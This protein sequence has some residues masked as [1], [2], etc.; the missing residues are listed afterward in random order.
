MSFIL[1]KSYVVN[2][3]GP[4]YLGDGIPLGFVHIATLA[5]HSRTSALFDM[6]VPKGR[7]SRRGFPF[8]WDIAPYL[9]AK[10]APC[11]HVES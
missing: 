3:L 1:S 11:P 4:E 6:A 5:H 2:G 7:P 8:V 10:R 9:H